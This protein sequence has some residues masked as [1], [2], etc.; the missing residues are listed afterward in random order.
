MRRLLINKVCWLLFALASVLATDKCCHAEM[1]TTLF[2]ANNGQSGNMFDINISAPNGVTIHAF[3]LNLDAGAWDINLYT[4]DGT[5]VGNEND[6]TAWTLHDSI[7]G[8]NSNGFDNPTNWDFAD[9]E[10]DVGP[11]AFYVEVTNGTALNYTNGTGVGNLVVDDGVIQI[12]EGTGNAQ[13]FGFVFQPR[14]WNGT[15]IYSVPESSAIH[16]LF[17]AAS[18]VLLRRRRGAFFA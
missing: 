15:I 1:V 5:H 3:D 7:S 16:L 6:P 10:L 14:I 4:L 2:A 9:L 12:F 8:L 17:A 18:T 13:N 11:Q